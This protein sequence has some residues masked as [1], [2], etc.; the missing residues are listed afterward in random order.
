MQLAL[1]NQ[2]KLRIGSL[3]IKL[4]SKQFA[5]VSRFSIYT[6]FDRNVKCPQ[7]P[8]FLS[9]QQQVWLKLNSHLCLDVIEFCNEIKE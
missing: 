4:T 5:Q 6:S 8:P 7:P 3:L 9:Q 1:A 2:S